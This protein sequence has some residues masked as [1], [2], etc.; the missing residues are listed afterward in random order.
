[1]GMIPIKL[2]FFTLL[3]ADDANSK[4]LPV[5]GF[6]TEL[7]FLTHR[8]LHLGKFSRKYSLGQLNHSIIYILNTKCEIFFL[9]VDDD[10][11]DTV[12]AERC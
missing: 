11:R 4:K 12:G 9:R 6:V 2:S 7:F 8:C 1:M 5:F 3:F 10:R